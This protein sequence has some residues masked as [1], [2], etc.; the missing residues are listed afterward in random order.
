MSAVF[1]EFSIP[2]NLIKKATYGT[3]SPITF[4]NDGFES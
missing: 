4:A 1:H 2:L 3:D